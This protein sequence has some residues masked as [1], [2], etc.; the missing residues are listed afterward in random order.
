MSFSRRNFLMAAGAAVAARGVLPASAQQ[1]PQQ[2][3]PRP[4]MDAW[5]GPDQP[6][7]YQTA[8]ST[9]ALVKGESSRRKNITDALVAID[10]QI[11]PVL[12]T[13]KYVVLKPNCVSTVALGTKIGRA[14][15]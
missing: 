14:H 2:Q 7:P 15:V 11:L 1:P 12:K 4:N 13:K 10:D 8:R 9:V 6:Y 5:T 3:P